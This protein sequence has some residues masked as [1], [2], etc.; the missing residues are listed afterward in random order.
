VLADRYFSGWSDIA[1][2]LARGID[3][4]VCHGARKVGQSG[5]R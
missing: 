4:V 1:L 3:I 2:P 5:A